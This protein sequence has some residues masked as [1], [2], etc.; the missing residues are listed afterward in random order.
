[1]PLLNPNGNNVMGY[2]HIPKI[3]QELAIGHGTG[4]ETLE[5]GVG[6]VEGTSL[7][8]GGEGTHAVLAGHRG[9]PTAKIFTD[10][11]QLIEG[12]KFFLYILDETLAYEIDQIE[13]VEP[14]NAEYLQIIEGQDLVSLVTCT[15]YGVNSHRMLIRGHRIPYEEEDIKLQAR[16]RRL[17]EREKPIVLAVVALICLFV[18]LAILRAIL[19]ARD[20]R[21]RQEED[22]RLIKEATEAASLAAQEAS[23]AA[24]AAEAAKDAAIAARDATEKRQID[25]AVERAT[26]ASD[27][28][29]GAA[30]AAQ[31]YSEAA[32]PQGKEE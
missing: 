19:A 12:D 4:T 20:R 13:I 23:K 17:P 7:P 8:I 11:D 27:E 30:D 3:G 29:K 18:F 9:L 31:E 22:Q 10:C 2:I 14:D 26:G 5:R 24:K 28:A 25:A 21:R 16:E 15:P 32:K 1:M 6:H